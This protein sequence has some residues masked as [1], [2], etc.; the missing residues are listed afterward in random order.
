MK[1]ERFLVCLLAGTCLALL[2]VQQKVSLIH[3]GY[4]VEE[5]RKIKIDLLDQH[6][7]IQYNVL[8]LRSPVI[9][10]RRLAVADVKLTPPQ[11]VEVVPS[12][13]SGFSTIAQGGWIQSNGVRGWLQGAVRVASRWLEGVRSAEAQ[14][15]LESG[16]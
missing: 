8:A 5:L 16:G 7:V 6:R 15:A 3:L 11:A 13:G 4:R 9:L 1:V 12:T 10:N 2:V 14:P